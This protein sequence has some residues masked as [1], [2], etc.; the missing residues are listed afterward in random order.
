MATYELAL[1]LSRGWYLLSFFEIFLQPDKN[2]DDGAM[3][4]VKLID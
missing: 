3:V 2:L 4:K 1:G